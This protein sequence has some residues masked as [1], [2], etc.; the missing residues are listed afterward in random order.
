MSTTDVKGIFAVGG[1]ATGVAVIAAS[2]SVAS[3]TDLTLTADAGTFAGSGNVQKVTLTSGATDNSTVQVLVQGTD[4]DGNA[5]QEFLQAPAGNS[6]V[7][8]TKFYNTVTRVIPPVAA[9]TSMS[10][11]V[12]S[13]GAFSTLFA[14][15]TRVRGMHGVIGTA[16]TMQFKTTSGEGTTVMSVAVAVGSLDPYIPDDGVLFTD[17]VYLV[18]NGT[19]TGLTVYLDK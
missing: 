18:H 6:T 17:G 4:V 1:T 3:D 15:R 11:G 13:D 12:T 2:Q 10:V 16:G 8:T 14:G 7:T 19:I 9:L 5:I